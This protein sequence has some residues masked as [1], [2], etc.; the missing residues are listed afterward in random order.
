MGLDDAIVVVR[1]LLYVTHRLEGITGRI[2]WLCLLLSKV[3]S[4]RLQ[5]L[6]AGSR[7]PRDLKVLIVEV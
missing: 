5:Q 1:L 4:V 3:Q 2:S 6:I 7:R